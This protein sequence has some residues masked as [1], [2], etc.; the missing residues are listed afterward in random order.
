VSIDGENDENWSA[1]DGRRVPPRNNRIKEI[2]EST[3]WGWVFLALASLALQATRTVSPS[4]I[5]LIL[6]DKGELGLTLA[7]DIEIIV[8]FL[9]YL[10][11]WR[12]FFNLGSNWLD[13]ILAIGSSIIQIPVIHESEVYPWLTA[14][15]LM[16]FYRVILEVPRMKPLLVRFILP[17]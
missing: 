17:P 15:Q 4:P 12:D 5:H 7:F 14:F 1:V 11:N 2:Y 3:I 16:R 10:P 13:L 9:A 8:R 6:L